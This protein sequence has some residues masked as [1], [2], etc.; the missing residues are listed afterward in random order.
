MNHGDEPDDLYH[1]PD[2]GGRPREYRPFQHQP[3]TA[4]AA[5]HGLT[6]LFF[7]TR[8]ETPLQRDSR[9]TKAAAICD[10]CPVINPC[11][12]QAADETK[13]GGVWGGIRAYNATPIDH[14]TERGY[15]QHY[16]RL[17]ETPCDECRQA[18]NTIQAARRQ[19]RQRS[20]SGTEARRQYMR[21]YYKQ[22]QARKQA[23]IEQMRQA[24]DFRNNG[25]HNLEW[26]G[27]AS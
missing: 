25:G 14:G 6:R 27:V 3:W 11:R 20:D 1:G 8:G 26:E 17:G 18:F 2:L 16:R 19:G 23:R 12:E 4:Q 22:Q 21:D 5:C 10:T 13:H 7:P 9:E 15:R 24:A